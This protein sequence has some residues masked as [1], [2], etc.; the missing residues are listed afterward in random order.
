MCVQNPLKVTIVNYE[1]EEEIEASYFPADVAK[2]GSRKM[3]FSKEIYIDRADFEE[4]P[5]KGY[6]RLTP[7]QPVRLKHAYIIKY[8][9]A[10]RDEDGTIVE[11]KVTYYP[12]SKSGS[13]T[14]GIKVKSAI[15]WVE[16]QH[17]KKVELRLYDRLFRV[18]NPQGIEDL[19]PDSLKI[20]KDALVEPAVIKEKEERFQFE[21]MAYFYKEPIDYSDDKPVFNKIVGLKDSWAKKTKPKEPKPQQK[22]KTE[23]KKEQKEGS[24]APM[25][26]EQQKLFDHY[27]K[28]LLLNKE[29]ANTL[30]RD[31]ILSSFY[32]E[33]LKSTPN[34]AISIANLV[35]NEVA[36]EL[37]QQEDSSK[38]K[39]TPKQI[40]DLASLI[41]DETIS[42]KI[43]KDV[44]EEM[45]Q[46]GEDPK[47]IVK[48]KGLEQ[49]SDPTVI[50]PIIEKII[51]Q[52]PD[53][54]EK[55]KNGNKKLFGFFIGQVLKA[56]GGKANPKV[57]NELVHK[58]LD[59]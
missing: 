45:K 44:F 24:V 36:R 52:N 39:F 17:A 35:V 46:N 19:N 51:E 56:T 6:Y 29:V 40:A 23:S 37:K 32:E 33:A 15:Q 38:L 30:A 49:I 9:D 3:P 47:T 5:P 2:E 34:A 57:V 16:A 55:Y 28:E 22:Q 14:S 48:R 43:A 1:G 18:E 12:D 42:T 21:R 11:L 54:V 31:E 58:A 27:T 8:E 59:S 20:V 41:Y 13:D 50:V 53:N 4:N 25:T 26:N 7:T 10:V